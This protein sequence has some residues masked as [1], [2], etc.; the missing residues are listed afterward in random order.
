MANDNETPGWRLQVLIVEDDAD[1]AAALAHVVQGFG[2]AA[3]VEADAAAALAWTERHAPDVV[4][5]DLGLPPGM[6]GHELARHLR[7]RLSEKPPLLVAVTGSTS[8]EDRRRSEE[9]GI[10]LHL[11]KPVEPEQVRSLLRRFERVIMPSC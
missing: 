1:T 9:A 7:Q 4:L 8:E 2:F 3:H 10:H 6:N 5:L 11:V